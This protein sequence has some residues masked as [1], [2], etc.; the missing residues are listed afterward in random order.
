[1]KVNNFSLIN[2]LLFTLLDDEN[3]RDRAKDKFSYND[4]V[5]FG[6][7]MRRSKE[8]PEKPTYIVKRYMF[9]SSQEFLEREEEIKSLCHLFNARFYI[10][11]TVKSLKSIAFDMSIEIPR[12]IKEESYPFVRRMFDSVADSNKGVRTSYRYW[13]V[14]ID[15][16]SHSKEV[17][18]HLIDNAGSFVGGIVPTVSGIHILVEPH[19]MTYLYDSP[20]KEFA[21]VKKNNMTL[22]Y[23]S[24]E[25]D[26]VDQ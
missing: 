13:I 8:N 21:D 10:S 16:M 17:L 12:I 7:V 11:T 26:E 3:I 4:K 18:K 24:D 14:D 23:Y 1:M 9:K 20:L 15:D 25:G 22:V 5:L 6:S 19:D 2:S